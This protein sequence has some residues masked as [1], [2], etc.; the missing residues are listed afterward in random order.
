MTTSAASTIAATSGTGP[1]RPVTIFAVQHA[2]CSWDSFW[3][4]VQAGITK[5]AEDN[6]VDVTVLAPDDFDLDKTA[7]LIEQAVAANP[8]GIM[9]T[10][11]DPVV[12]NS[13]A[14]CG[15]SLNFARPP[16]SPNELATW[17]VIK[18]LYR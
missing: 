9:L 10:V 2:E 17:G 18:G 15:W 3:C 13:G 1:N 12:G 16:A 6:N 11:T 14:I 5:G 7:S 4:T 8:D